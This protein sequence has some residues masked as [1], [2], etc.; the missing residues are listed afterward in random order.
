MQNFKKEMGD[1]STKQSK[2]NAF[3]NNE[4]DPYAHPSSNENLNYDEKPLRSAGNDLEEI[5]QDNISNNMDSKPPKNTKKRPFLKRSSKSK[6]PQK[7]P[8]YKYYASNFKQSKEQEFTPKESKQKPKIGNRSASV[9]HKMHSTPVE[10]PEDNLEYNSVEEFEKLEEECNNDTMDN[11]PVQPE[12]SFPRQPEQNVKQNTHNNVQQN[13]QS[14]FRKAPPAQKQKPLTAMEM[15][16]R[17]MKEKKMKLFDDFESDPS[18]PSSDEE[19]V[20]KVVQKQGKKSNVVKRM[21]FNQPS[22]PAP[23]P[24]AAEPKD[25]ISPELEQILTQ[26]KNELDFIIQNDK[27][28]YEI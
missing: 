3:Q 10:I 23:K 18:E 26:K 5:N 9:S 7:A 4:N 24:K 25:I 6:L 8:K 28:E 16:E 12:I 2:S 17:K 14:N 21:I 1:Y 22:E 27:R 15:V 13:P 11:K 19:P 20:Q